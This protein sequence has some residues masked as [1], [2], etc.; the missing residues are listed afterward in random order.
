MSASAGPVT[1]LATVVR[2]ANN[3]V[4]DATN[5]IRPGDTL[6]IWLTGMGLT[7]PGVAAGLASPSTP[8]ALAETQPTVTLGGTPL[9]IEYAGLAPG[10]VGVNQIN[11]GV[12]FGVPQGPSEP[13]VITQNTGTTTLNFRVVG[14]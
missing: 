14:N 3:Q 13:L 4:V 1:G 8:L 6:V 12:P 7:T 10:E 11:V 5:P 2:A 9:S